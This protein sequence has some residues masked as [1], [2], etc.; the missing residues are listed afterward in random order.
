MASIETSIVV[1]RPVEEVFHFVSEPRNATAWAPAIH[2]VTT[3]GPMGPG[4][5]GREVRTFLGR[6]MVMEWVVSEY[7]PNRRVG[8]KYTTGPVPATAI[9]TFEPVAEGTRMTCRS[10]IEGRGIFRLVEPLMAWEGKKE[11]ETNFRTLKQL[12][13]GGEARNGNTGKEM[14]R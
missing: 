8:F 10:N 2:E 13:E 11:D 12:L 5:R 1:N 3:D 9:F 6:R 7:E 4:T 14:E